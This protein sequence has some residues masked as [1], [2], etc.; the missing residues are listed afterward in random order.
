MQGNKSGIIYEINTPWSI[1]P[2]GNL[3]SQHKLIVF[4]NLN[5]KNIENVPS[6]VSNLLEHRN[7]LVV[8]KSHNVADVS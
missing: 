3:E 7:K 6:I 5:M 2:L 4:N 8:E 1:H